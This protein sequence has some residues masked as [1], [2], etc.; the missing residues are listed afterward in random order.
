MP[1]KA[2]AKP[3]APTK[4]KPRQFARGLVRS[5]TW[6]TS[7]SKPTQ[8]DDGS[9]EV[10]EAKASMLLRERSSWEGTKRAGDKAAFNARYALAEQLGE[11]G[12]GVVHHVTRK[13]DGGDYAAK[14]ASG[15][16]LWTA[17][18]KEAKTW[19]AVSSP[20]H[21]SILPL[22]EVYEEI[23]SELVLMTEI[24]LGGDLT[25]AVFAVE[26]SEQ[27]C[28]LMCV[29]VASALA[30]LHCVHSYAHRDL[31]PHNVLCKDFDPTLIGSLKVSSNCGAQPALC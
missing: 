12:F 29:Q 26:M 1:P 27:A 9:T 10:L 4:S 20:Y 6:K 3:A 5:L 23:G 11:G 18:L 19:E 16:E 14:V 8:E 13:S 25:E 2:K 30:H 22:I 17:A 28:R 21:P 7:S 31:K 24:M 15:K